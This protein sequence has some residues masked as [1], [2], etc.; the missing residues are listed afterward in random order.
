MPVEAQ[1]YSSWEKG[2]LNTPVQWNKK[3][4]PDRGDL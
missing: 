4:A 1:K 2:C 3:N